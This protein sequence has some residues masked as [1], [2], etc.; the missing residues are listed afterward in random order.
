MMNTDMRV[1]EQDDYVATYELYETKDG[2]ELRLKD[3]RLSRIGDGKDV[4]KWQALAADALTAATK[5]KAEADG[6][7]AS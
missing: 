6:I 4:K 7:K 3:V 2:P 1:T 5:A